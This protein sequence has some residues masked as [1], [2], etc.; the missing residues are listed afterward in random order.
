M[1]KCKICGAI[2]HEDDLEE[3]IIH[4]DYYTPAERILRCPCCGENEV[5]E[6]KRCEHCG[7]YYTEDELTEGFC[8]ECI[9][10]YLTDRTRFKKYLLKTEQLTTFI[11]WVLGKKEP[12]VVSRKQLVECL[13]YFDERITYKQIKQFVFESGKYSVNNYVEW[14]RE[15]VEK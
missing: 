2:F 10:G 6:A 9:E 8:D 4:G 12:K 3:K 13:I 15:E 14:L 11:A 5:E 1:L 7:S